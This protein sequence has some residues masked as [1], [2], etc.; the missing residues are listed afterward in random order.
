MLNRMLNRPV[1]VTMILLVIAV[2][3]AVSINRLPVSL[4][5]DVD[6]PYITVQVTAPHLSAREM[7]ETVSRP[8]RHQLIQTSFLEDLRSESADGSCKLVLTFRQGADM[9]YIAIEVNEKIDR[10]MGSLKNIE[11]PKVYKSGAED[12]PVFYIN[13]TLKDGMPMSGNTDMEL[14]PV[15]DRF[16]EMSQFASEVVAKRLEQLDEVAMVDLSGCVKPEILIIPDEEALRSL[17]ITEN[18]LASLIE[19]ANIRLGSLSIRDGEYR[20]SVK[21][22]SFVSNKDDIGNIYINA[23]GKIVQIKDIAQVIEH[24]SK[25]TGL[26][27]SDGNDAVTMAVIKQSDARMADM[28]RSVG[29]LVARLGDEYPEVEFTVTRDQTE[30]L[31]YSINNLIENIIYGIILACMIIFLFMKDF[32][33][34][35]LVAFTIPSALIFSMLVFYAIGLTINIISL[36]GLILGVGMMVD[37]TIILTDNITSRWQRGEKLR[38]A[39]VRGTKEVSAPM[40]SSVLTTCAV[41]IPL[42]FVSGTAGAL[43]YDQAMAVTVVLLTS[44]VVTVTVIPVYYWCW[45]RKQTKFMPNAILEKFSFDRMENM[46]E[47]SV[48]WLFRHRWTGWMVFFLSIAGTALCFVRMPKEN[49]PEITYTDTVL[50]VDWNDHVSLEENKRRT[51]EIETEARAYTTHYTSMVG[52]QQFVLGH[53]GEQPVSS[54]SLYMECRDARGLDSLKKNIAS[55]LE[56]KY[57]LSLYGF[58]NSGNIFD[59]VFASKEADIIARLRPLSSADIEPEYLA[60]LTDRLAS[61]FPE[62][63]IQEVPMKKDIVYVTDPEK[64]TLYGVSYQDIVSVLKNTLNENE[65]FDIVKGSSTL[66]VV[67]GTDIRNM[68]KIMAESYVKKDGYEIPLRSLLAQTCR[69]DLRYIISGSDGNYYPVEMKY[70]G[71]DPSQLMERLRA[72]VHEDGRFDVSFGGS[73]FANMNM[74]RELAMVL[75]IALVL[76]YLILASQFESLVQPLIILSEI[77]IDIFGA[78]A[79]LWL[80]GATINLMSM[81]GLVVIC[82]IVINDSILK[83][84]TINR[85]R[86]SGLG[87]KHAVMEAGHRRLKAIVM[88]SLTT[89]LSV[90]PFLSRGSMGSDLQ[91][92]MSVVIIAGMTIGTVVSL[93]FVPMVYYE[94][95]R[96]K[97]DGR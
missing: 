14:F 84:D 17:G 95:Y 33:S 94:I 61:D 76:L 48:K 97:E 20:Y 72:I 59:A 38:Q 34:P 82:G 26:V 86:R 44:Y 35:A 2:L 93:L 58:E 13:M 50:K 60:V 45:Y 3:G 87:L 16:R 96:G 67:M 64:M 19:D 32:R 62:A 81:I 30:L 10:T 49:L 8:L 21:F 46:Y 56:K 80:C 47:R 28:K 55:F 1:T 12:I 52:A 73:W 18:R 37:N 69:S 91:Y 66:P 85:L 42:V 90:C 31:E 83:I 70:K 4:I 23:D 40:L 89:I 9:D 92:P 88:T 41:F 71:N 11:R 57:P 36:S 29:D 6:I 27:R 78:L 15:S 75:L 51:E 79:V 65:L 54:T 5:P 77:V 7:D 22:Q 39:V 68:E 53:S 43:F 74:I 63:G 25:R 24:P